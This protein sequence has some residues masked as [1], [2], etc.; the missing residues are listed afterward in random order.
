MSGGLVVE[1]LRVEAAGVALVEAASLSVAPGKVLGLVG[2]SGSGKSLSVMSIPGLLPL[3]VAMAGGAISLDGRRLDTLSEP[4][5]RRIRGKDIGVVF[6]DPFTSLN[7]VRRIGSLIEESLKRHSGLTPGEAKARAVAA[8]ADVGLPEPEAKARAYPHQ[9]SGGQRQRALIALA[10][11]NRPRLLIADEPTTALDATV[12]VQI[13]DLFRRAAATSGAA[14]ILVTHDLGAA[15][16]LCDDVAVMYAGRIVERGATA[17]IVSAPAHPYT[18]ALLA[19]APRM[20]VRSRPAPIPGQPP[21]PSERGPGCAFAPRCARVLA[22]CS[23]A[24][25]P[26]VAVPA[27]AGEAAC[28]NPVSVGATA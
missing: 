23:E 27:G 1:E 21:A 19:C 28:L 6:Q 4:E 7:P 13:L 25:P 17:R 8:L 18:A 24:S 14:T 5:M 3:G 12:Q 15:A 20:D 2:E 16:Y 9:L 22:K 10:L 26:L 11:A